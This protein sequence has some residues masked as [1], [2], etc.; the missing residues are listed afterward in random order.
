MLSLSRA[1]FTPWILVLPLLGGC[2]APKF[3]PVRGQVILFGVGPLTEGEVR[4]QPVS[5]PD[6]IASGRIQK[7]GT[8]SLSTPA[9]GTGVLEGACKAAVVVEPRQGK[10]VIDNRFSDFDTSDRQFTVTARDENYFIVE[11]SRPGKSP[12]NR[13]D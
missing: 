2:G 4:F 3:Y 13:S 9:H 6:L 10:P 8:F 1:A 12:L 7:D 11:V 5:K